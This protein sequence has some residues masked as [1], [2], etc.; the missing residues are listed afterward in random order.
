MQ[1]LIS[2]GNIELG[3]KKVGDQRDTGTQCRCLGSI[4]SKIA[5][6]L[7]FIKFIPGMQILEKR[8]FWGEGLVT[9]FGL[10]TFILMMKKKIQGNPNKRFQF[11]EYIDVLP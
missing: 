11:S 8:D 9:Y 1:G 10:T 4:I 7:Q 2:E 6:T 3:G 5:H